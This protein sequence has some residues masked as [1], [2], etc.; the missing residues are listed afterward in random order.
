MNIMIDIETL[1]TSSNA[2]I[3][4]LGA[5]VFDPIKGIV[6]ETFYEVIDPDS[7][8]NAGGIMDLSTVKWWLEQSLE[9]QMIFRTAGNSIYVV[10]EAFTNW[11]N[12]IRLST[13]TNN[14]S[15]WGN[16]SDF[17]NVILAN[18]YRRL[19]MPVPWSH[20]ENRCYRTMYNL[21]PEIPFQREGIAHNA[22]HDA[23]T[24]AKHLIKIFQLIKTGKWSE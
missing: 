8:L 3:I 6:E 5:C 17:D 16:G 2:A 14:L 23:F 22:I 12:K 4:S 21:F 24:Q 15:I 19:G 7:S 13:M 11:L 9:A 1:G 10:L 20:K 18:A